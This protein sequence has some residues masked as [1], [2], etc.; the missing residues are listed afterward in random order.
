MGEA[1]TDAIITLEVTR[2]KNGKWW[3]Y[4]HN[5]S[6]NHFNMDEEDMQLVSEINVKLQKMGISIDEHLIKAHPNKSLIKSELQWREAQSSIYDEKT[7]KGIIFN[8]EGQPTAGTMSDECMQE[9]MT[10]ETWEKYVR[11]RDDSRT[12][13]KD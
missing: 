12:N 9:R 11:W 3:T 13:K 1:F 5:H 8:K 7:H 10:P 4:G 2:D 6:M